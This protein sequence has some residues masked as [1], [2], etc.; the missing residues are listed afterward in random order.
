MA[1]EVTSQNAN[2]IYGM[3]ESY[4][5]SACATRKGANSKAYLFPGFTTHEVAMMGDAAMSTSH[6]GLFRSA[7]DKIANNYVRQVFLESVAQ[8]L[9]CQVDELPSIF[10]WAGKLDDLKVGDFGKGKP[11]TARRIMA[12]TNAVSDIQ[13]LYNAEKT[14]PQS[15]G[16]LVRHEVP[17]RIINKTPKFAEATI[18]NIHGYEE[19]IHGHNGDILV[20]EQKRIAQHSHDLPKDMIDIL[21]DD[22]EEWCTPWTELEK[23]R[24]G[25]ADLALKND[26]DW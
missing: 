11:L 25:V 22:E 23:L 14:Y 19:S 20:A 2:S 16:S 3:F 15:I 21:D 24:Q 6:Q 8:K 17:S 5:Q 13:A 12:I 18:R 4:A 9:G 26:E 7:D 10:K 1:I